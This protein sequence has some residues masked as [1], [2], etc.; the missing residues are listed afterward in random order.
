MTDQTQNKHTAR[1]KLLKSVVAGG[2]VFAVGKMLPESWTRPVVQAVALPAHAQTSPG[3]F[4]GLYVQDRRI[5]FSQ[6][7]EVRERSILDMFVSPAQAASFFCNAVTRIQISVNGDQADVCLSTFTGDAE[8]GSTDVNLNTGE[9]GDINSVGAS[10]VG[11]S[12]MRVNS[13]ASQVTGILNGCGEFVANRT[14]GPFQCL[15][16]LTSNSYLSSPFANKA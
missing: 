4:D 11:M 9:F 13:D 7:V 12:N 1:R 15:A 3:N 8:Q 2:G 14:P 6:P 16:N 5:A 10:T